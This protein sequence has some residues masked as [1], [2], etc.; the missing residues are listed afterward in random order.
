M[1]VSLGEKQKH[2]RIGGERMGEEKDTTFFDFRLVERWETTKMTTKTV[3]QEQMS[4][5]FSLLSSLPSSTP[6][7]TFCRFFFFF[8]LPNDSR[9]RSSSY[10]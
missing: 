9:S 8:F 6:M 10:G 2:I 1:T 5:P 7:S 3:E 4:S